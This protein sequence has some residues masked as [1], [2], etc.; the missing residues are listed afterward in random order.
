MVT[1]ST[2]YTQTTTE[3]STITSVRTQ[4]VISSANYT[5]TQ[6]TTNNFTDIVSDTVTQNETSTSTT[7][8]TVTTPFPWYGLVYLSADP[9]CS[10]SYGETSYP[11]PCF[12]SSGYLFNCAAAATNS[13]GCTQQVNITGTNESFT[14][15]IWYPYTNSIGEQPVQNCKWTVQLP[16]PPGPETG[17]AYCISVN[18]TSFLVSEPAQGAV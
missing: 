3:I 8:E 14:V 6:T 4:L 7:T 13:E 11:V 5:I 10:T 18:S 2:N 12:G 17:Y 9:G 15:T 1:R 16:S